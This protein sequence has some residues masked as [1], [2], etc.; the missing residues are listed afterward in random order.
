[1]TKPT[2]SGGIEGEHPDE[3]G[4]R[5]RQVAEREYDPDGS[6][7]LTT[8]VVLA[9]A[10]ATDVSP[11]ALEPPLYDSVDVESIED[12]FGWRATTGT[13][14]TDARRVEFR[15]GDTLVTVNADGRIDVATPASRG[16]A[17]QTC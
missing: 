1:M 6:R 15:Y 3:T 7:D 12:I 10:E 16:T 11:M 9:V 8:A 17:G 2:D 5:W 13:D 14:T 4:G